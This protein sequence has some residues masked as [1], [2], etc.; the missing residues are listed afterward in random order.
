MKQ[1][2]NFTVLRPTAIVEGQVQSQASQCGI[3]GRRIGMGT[4][5]SLSNT[6]FLSLLFHDSTNIQLYITDTI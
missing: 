1:E 2:I 3:C 4:G 6:V 5:F